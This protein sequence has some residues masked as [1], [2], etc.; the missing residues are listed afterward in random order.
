MKIKRLIKIDFNNFLNSNNINEEVLFSCIDDKELTSIEKIK[1]NLSEVKFTPYT[2]WDGEVY[3]KFRIENETF[4]KLV[5]KNEIGNDFYDLEETEGNK[6]T[7]QITQDDKV[8][9]SLEDFN[10]FSTLEISKDKAIKL[11]KK[12]IGIC[13]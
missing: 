2:G 8:H 3:P 6:I 11:A 12:M 5:I 4:K 7:I 9:I 10:D 1:K 13:S